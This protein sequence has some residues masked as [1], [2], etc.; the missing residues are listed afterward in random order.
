MYC[1][2]S[3]SAPI[4]DTGN[5]RKEALAEGLGLSVIAHGLSHFPIGSPLDPSR[6]LVS[7]SRYVAPKFA[8]ADRQTEWQTDKS[9]YNGCK[10]WAVANQYPADD[11]GRRP[12]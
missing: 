2:A 4:V 7:F 10:N 3:L 11:V 6:Y 8:D 5:G 12:D 1:F 9:G